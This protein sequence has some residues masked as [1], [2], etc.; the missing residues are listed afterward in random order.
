MV[1]LFFL[2]SAF[3]QNAHSRIESERSKLS[4]KVESLSSDKI[5]LEKR[6][7]ELN[8]GDAKKSQGQQVRKKDTNALAT[9]KQINLKIAAVFIKTFY[10]CATY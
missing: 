8:R 5:S 7:E 2:L 3:L 1:C 6:V 4:S 10:L 9:K